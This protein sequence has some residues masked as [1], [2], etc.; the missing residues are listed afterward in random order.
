MAVLSLFNGTTWHGPQVVEVPT[1][2]IATPGSLDWRRVHL[3]VGG[4]TLPFSIREGRAHWQTRARAPITKPE[5]EDLLVFT[6]A[7]PP[8]EWARVHVLGGGAPHLAKHLVRDHGRYVILYDALRVVIDEK[9]GQLCELSFMGEPLLAGPLTNTIARLSKEA[10]YEVAGAFGPGYADPADPAGPRV[11]VNRREAVPCRVRRASTSS[12]GAMTELNFLLETSTNLS[13]ALTYRVYA[14][15]VVD[16][17]ADGQPWQGGSPWCAYAAAFDLPMAGKPAAIPYI[18]DRFPFYGFKGYTASVKQTAYVRRGT[19]AGVVELGEETVNGRR[20]MRRLAPYRLDDDPAVKSLIEALDTGYVVD[21]LPVR[22]ALPETRLKVA[23]PASAQA[24]QDVLVKALQA[25]GVPAEAVLGTDSSAM[26]KMELVPVPTREDITGDGF[27]I[28]S[29]GPKRGASVR[30][31]TRLG[32]YQAATATAAHLANSNVPSIPLVSRNPVVSL[33]GGGFGGGDFEVDFPYG[34]EEEWKRTLDNLAMSGRNCFACLG[35][36]G[37][38]KMPVSYSYMPELR[39]SA[40]DAFDESSG[41]KFTE[42]AQHRER[43]LRLTR[44]L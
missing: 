30:A 26:L 40:P 7:V 2:R 44:F 29:L 10:P 23:C 24:A 42:I 18:E 21:V 34:S 25:A 31:G 20:W 16:I 6:C 12:T 27:Q 22:T 14:N 32:L 39:S 1:G 19:R 33:R 8:G 41:A 43:G 13:I 17:I 15:G 3:Q 11:I 35:M 4:Q 5:A 36:W 38:W 37:N 28:R 9:S